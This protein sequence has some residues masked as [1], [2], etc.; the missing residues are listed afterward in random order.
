LGLVFGRIGCFGYGCCYGDVTETFPLRV[1][2]P[3]RFV[4]AID[5]RTGKPALLPEGSPAFVD[6]V[7]K[8][9]LKGE[10]PGPAKSLPVYPTQLME[11][12]NSLI[13][14]LIGS[15]FFRYRKRYGE[16]FFLVVILYCIQRYILEILRADNPPILIGL[17]ISQVFSLVFGALCMV[18]FVQSRMQPSNVVAAPA[19]HK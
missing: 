8:G 2:F 4:S 5:T 10:K 12:F 17:M 6:Q 7:A 9:Q 11:S 14:C 16:V 3:G 13:I 15:F 1:Q 18:L 19:S